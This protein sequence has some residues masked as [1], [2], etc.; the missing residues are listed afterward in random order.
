M[1]TKQL[2]RVAMRS[3]LYSISATFIIQVMRTYPPIAAASAFGC[4]EAAQS[5]R[6]SQSLIRYHGPSRLIHGQFTVGCV[7][8]RFLILPLL[9]ALT[10]KYRNVPLCF[11][12]FP[13]T[14]L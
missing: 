4:I 6:H 7:G 13:T 11:R 12:D 2:A 1:H 3:V 10:I 14:V 5:I 9:F 8:L